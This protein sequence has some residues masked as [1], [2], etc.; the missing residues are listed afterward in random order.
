MISSCPHLALTWLAGSTINGLI[1]CFAIVCLWVLSISSENIFRLCVSF[2]LKEFQWQQLYQIWPYMGL[3]IASLCVLNPI[4]SSSNVS[5]SKMY[6]NLD[7]VIH[8]AFSPPDL[9]PNIISS[10][11]WLTLVFEASTSLGATTLLLTFNTQWIT[12]MNI[13]FANL[14]RVLPTDLL[15]CSPKSLATVYWPL[16]PLFLP[17]QIWLAHLFNI[18]TTHGH[19]I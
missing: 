17:S 8:W 16:L 2:D 4:H 9:F 15:T 3:I 12:I 6:L 19:W 1:T 14:E 5:Y 7:V 11:M 10:S 13:G 18:I